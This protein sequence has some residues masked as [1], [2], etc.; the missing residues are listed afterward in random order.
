MIHS[1]NRS[2]AASFSPKQLSEPSPAECSFVAKASRDRSGRESR[3]SRSALSPGT[4]GCGRSRQRTEFAGPPIPEQPRSEYCVGTGRPRT[5]AT[6]TI[7]GQLLGQAERSSHRCRHTRCPNS[8][9]NGSGPSVCIRA[10]KGDELAPRSGHSRLPL[11]LR[12]QQSVLAEV[13][14]ASKRRRGKSRSATGPRVGCRSGRTPEVSQ[15]SPRR[16]TESCGNR[17]EHQRRGCGR[18]LLDCPGQAE[19]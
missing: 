4:P 19:V 6:T 3:S 5:V 2:C 13:D 16:L 7:T 12:D 9:L 8:V 11:C 10:R 18:P 17:P 1:A 14:R 15:R